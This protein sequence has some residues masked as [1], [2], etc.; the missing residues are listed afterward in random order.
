MTKDIV[1]P[2][3]PKDSL[4]LDDLLTTEIL[5]SNEGGT[6]TIN[7][8]ISRLDNENKFKLMDSI[9]IE[10]ISSF[11]KPEEVNDNHS[12]LIDM[13]DLMRDEFKRVQNLTTNHEIWGLCD[14]AMGN[15]TQRIPVIKQRDDLAAEVIKLKKLLSDAEDILS[16]VSSLTKNKIK[17]TAEHKNKDVADESAHPSMTE[18]CPSCHSILPSDTVPMCPECGWIMPYSMD[19]PSGHTVL[20]TEKETMSTL[21]TSQMIISAIMSDISDRSGIGDVLDDIDD[22]TIDGMKHKWD[23]LIQHI[24]N[25]KNIKKDDVSTLGHIPSDYM[26]PEDTSPLSLSDKA[27]NIVG[28]RSFNEKDYAA[29]KVDDSYFCFPTINNWAYAAISPDYVPTKRD[30]LVWSAAR[31]KSE[32]IKFKKD[33]LICLTCG[34]ERRPISELVK[35]LEDSNRVFGLVRDYIDTCHNGP[36]VGMEMLIDKTVTHNAEVIDAS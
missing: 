30:R 10:M 5:D 16:Q 31:I 6:V 3:P 13:V 34:R 26:G 15:I 28:D 1:T 19:P 24:L 2:R 18:F 36:Y 20:I 33:N 22:I 9:Y 29:L 11:K 8:L 32:I 7:T 25:L 23:D 12:K 21:G 14:R 27:I 35:S 4:T 17:K